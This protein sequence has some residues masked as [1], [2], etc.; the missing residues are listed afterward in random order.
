MGDIRPALRDDLLTYLFCTS[1]DRP[2]A[3]SPSYL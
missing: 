3:S 1:P 2:P